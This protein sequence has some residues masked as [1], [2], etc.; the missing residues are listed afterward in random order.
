[1]NLNSNRKLTSISSTGGGLTAR[2]RQSRNDDKK[3][4]EVSGNVLAKVQTCLFYFM[5]LIFLVALL[6]V[7]RKIEVLEGKVADLEI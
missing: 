1:M 4:I 5:V 3:V 2:S 7:Q 6:E